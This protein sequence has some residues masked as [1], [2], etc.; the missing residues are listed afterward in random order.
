[1]GVS[2]V[3]AFSLTMFIGLATFGS[4]FLVVTNVV[5]TVEKS[6]SVRQSL[7][8]DQLNSKISIGSVSLSGNDLILMVTNNGSIPLWDFQ[9][10]A[11]IIQY[12]ANISNK[13][14]LLV[15]LYNFSNSPSSYQWTSSQILEPD[16]SSEFQIVLPY[17]PYPNTPAVAVISTNYGTSAVWRGTL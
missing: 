1:M 10:F 16:G 3:I 15:S 8:L 2:N 17:P 6:E 11:V 12:Y 7:Y 4:I 9:H 14:T 13:S 5:G